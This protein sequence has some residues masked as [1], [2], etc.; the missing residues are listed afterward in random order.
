MI[1]KKLRWTKNNV[2]KPFTSVDHVHIFK[3][4]ILTSADEIKTCKWR[5]QNFCQQSLN[6]KLT[7]FFC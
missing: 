5:N 6:K 1:Y 4:A 7:N 3:I 2:K